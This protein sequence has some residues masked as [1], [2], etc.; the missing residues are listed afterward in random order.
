[1]LGFKK[2][3]GCVLGRGWDAPASGHVGRK[4]TRKGTPGVTS[5]PA[6]VPALRAMGGPPAASKRSRQRLAFSHLRPPSGLQGGKFL[7]PPRA[8]RRPPPRSAPQSSEDSMWLMEVVRGRRVCERGQCARLGTIPRC[9]F[10]LG[11][12]AQMLLLI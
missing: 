12:Q 1:M 7:R 2:V 6:E 11:A 4:V 8:P 10:P 3:S 5:S 9:D